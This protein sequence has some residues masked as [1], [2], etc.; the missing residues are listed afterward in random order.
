M[1]NLSITVAGQSGSGYAI[2]A[3]PKDILVPQIMVRVERLKVGQLALVEKVSGEPAYHIGD[4]GISIVEAVLPSKLAVSR[5]IENVMSH[6]LDN[7]FDK[8]V[9]IAARN[10]RRHLKDRLDA[11]VGTAHDLGMKNAN[12]IYVAVFEPP[13]SVP[14]PED[15]TRYWM[16]G[17]SM[18]MC[19][20]HTPETPV[21]VPYDSL[22]AKPPTNEGFFPIRQ[23]PYSKAWWHTMAVRLHLGFD[24]DGKLGP[25]LTGVDLRV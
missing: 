8:S 11:L 4:D 20:V 1:K 14:C 2:V 23:E 24:Q 9:A 13:A 19:I 5:F 3:E 16:T 6:V 22:W 7:E 18:A 15:Q 21:G 10:I 12:Q 25:V 17:Y